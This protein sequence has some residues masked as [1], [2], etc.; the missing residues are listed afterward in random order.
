[1]MMDFFYPIGSNLIHLFNSD[2]SLQRRY[3]VSD[4]QPALTLLTCDYLIR[5]TKQRME[6]LEVVDPTTSNSLPDT[7]HAVPHFNAH[8]LLVFS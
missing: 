1:M 3:H 8:K 4:H 6:Y 2:P 7:V 5:G